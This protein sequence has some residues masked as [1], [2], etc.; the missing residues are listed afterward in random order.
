M[1]MGQ[2]KGGDFYFPLDD[3]TA[4]NHCTQDGFAS[5]TESSGRNGSHTMERIW[6]IQKEGSAE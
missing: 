2:N 5:Y 6:Y 4:S 1:Y 3:S